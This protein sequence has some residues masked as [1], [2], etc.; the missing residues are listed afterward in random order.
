MVTAF[1]ELTANGGDIFVNNCSNIG[2]EVVVS[3]MKKKCKELC[4]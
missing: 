3:S 4:I 2:L 1:T